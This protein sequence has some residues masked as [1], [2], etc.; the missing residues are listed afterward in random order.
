VGAKDGEIGIVHVAASRRAHACKMSCHIKLF[1]NFSW[2][3]KSPST[4][5]KQSTRDTC[6]E[7]AAQKNNCEFNLAGPR[8]DPYIPRLNQPDVPAGS[9]GHLTSGVSKRIVY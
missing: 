9:E 6:F 1:C 4:H 3:H 5:W 2:F 8:Q 7:P